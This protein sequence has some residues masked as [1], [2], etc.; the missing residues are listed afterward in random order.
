MFLTRKFIL[1]PGHGVFNGNFIVL[2][3]GTYA[4]DSHVKM[5]S[6]LALFRL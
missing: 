4:F 3:S 1:D 5:L 2:T 6:R